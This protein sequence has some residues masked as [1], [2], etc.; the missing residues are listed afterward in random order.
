M[1]ISNHFDYLGRVNQGYTAPAISNS[2]KNNHEILYNTFNPDDVG[3]EHIRCNWRGRIELSVRIL[4]GVYYHGNVES[5]VGEGTIY[6]LEKY[7]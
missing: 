5:M 2:F 3:N 4:S 6:A 1:V 7:K